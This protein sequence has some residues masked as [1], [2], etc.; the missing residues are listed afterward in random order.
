[1]HDLT[2]FVTDRLRTIRRGQENVHNVRHDANKNSCEINLISLLYIFFVLFCFV[3]L[4]GH[5]TWQMD[6]ELTFISGSLLLLK[7]LFHFKFDYCLF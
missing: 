6:I 1:M 2:T 3:Y 7:F 5:A 4:C